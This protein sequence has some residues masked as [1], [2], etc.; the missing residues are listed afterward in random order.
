M[1]VAF[2]RPLQSLQLPITQFGTP[3]QEQWFRSLFHIVQ[4]VIASN[5]R[6]RRLLGWG[7]SV[8]I[9]GHLPNCD[10][11]CPF[12]GQRAIRSSQSAL[13]GVLYY[14]T[15]DWAQLFPRADA[16]GGTGL[17]EASL[18]DAGVETAPVSSRNQRASH[19]GVRDAYAHCTGPRTGHI[20]CRRNT[21]IVQG[22]TAC[23]DREVRFTRNR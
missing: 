1:I 23:V 13:D 7:S 19:R 21:R 3:P 15:R 9:T 6:T 10:T 18:E 8:T 11:P 16:A 17:E 2:L 4:G 20:G 14:L 12:P 5:V 22:S